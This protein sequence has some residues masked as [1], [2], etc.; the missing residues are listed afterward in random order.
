M[1]QHIVN[2]KET[3]SVTFT[4]PEGDVY[5]ELAAYNAYQQL[6]YLESLKMPGL[7]PWSLVLGTVNISYNDEGYPTAVAY[8]VNGSKQAQTLVN[9]SRSL[10]T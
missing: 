9:L 8:T 7:N 5:A 6:V 4:S 1:G 2:G 3:V 10:Y